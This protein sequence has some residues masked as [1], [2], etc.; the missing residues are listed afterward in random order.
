M[1]DITGFKTA[2]GEV[3]KIDANTISLGEN[4]PN[5]GDVL[6]YK[7]ETIKWVTP[8]EQVQADWEQSDNT[9][10][11]YIK[12]KPDIPEP[13]Y[14]SIYLNNQNELYVNPNGFVGLHSGGLAISGNNN[15]IVVAV[16][17]NGGLNIDNDEGVGL[18]VGTDDTITHIR[19][20]GQNL[21]S[22]T[23]PV[24][25]P[26]NEEYKKILINREGRLDWDDISDA[27]MIFGSGSDIMYLKSAMLT[28]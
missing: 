7:D 17:T 18:A 26:S 2:T 3:Q 16:K 21:I 14:Y 9:K 8:T 27:N 24:P 10:K 23:N 28:I 22:V 6:T 11:D 1:A 20:G 19:Q 5:D 15:E 4:T 12:N 13:D 25:D